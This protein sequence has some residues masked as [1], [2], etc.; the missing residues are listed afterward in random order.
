MPSA[1]LDQIKILEARDE[2]L[3]VLNATNHS[4]FFHEMMRPEDEEIFHM[5]RRLPEMVERFLDSSPKE[6]KS[7]PVQVEYLGKGRV[8]KREPGK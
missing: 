5:S 2:L 8:A 6:Q 4:P 3:S 1:S 7:N